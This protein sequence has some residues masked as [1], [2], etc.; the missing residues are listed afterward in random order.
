MEGW[1]PRRASDA[2]R[3]WRQQLEE[4]LLLGEAG[5]FFFPV[6]LLVS[7]D[8]SLSCRHFPEMFDDSSVTLPVSEG[9]VRCDQEPPVCVD[10]R[11]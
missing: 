11:G 1:R 3:I 8:S 9:G 6:R 10:L 7:P 4:S 2:D 5:L